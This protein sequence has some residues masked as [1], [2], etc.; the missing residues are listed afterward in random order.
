MRPL[1]LILIYCC[2]PS[3]LVDKIPRSA[4]F[5]FKL[6]VSKLT[7]YNSKFE[8]L[9]EETVKNVAEFEIYLKCQITF[10]QELEYESLDI[11]LVKTVMHQTLQFTN[12]LVNYL[13]VLDNAMEI[14]SLDNKVTSQAVFFV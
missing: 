9:E 13:K 5:N 8:V 2:S 6:A 10:L 14:A 1:L 11:K 12:L 3:T 7:I 4:C